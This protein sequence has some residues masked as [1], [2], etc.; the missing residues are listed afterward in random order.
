MTNQVA[1]I[2]KA[3][4]L[5]LAALL[6]A[7]EERSSASA[8]DRLPILKINSKRKDEQG[9]KLEQGLFMLQGGTDEPVYASKVQI[10][11]LSQLF[12]WIHF[13][14]EEKKVE[15]KTLMIPNFGMEAR[16]M[17]GGIRCGKPT[18][19]VL[20]EMPKAEQKKFEDIKC[21]RQLRV[22]VS[23]TGKDADGDEHTIENMPAI[24]FLKGAN[25]NPFNDE[26]IKA[27][28]KGANL[29]DYNIEVTAE[30][31]E[32]GSVV[33]YVMHFKPELKTKLGLDQPTYD[34]MLHMAK[35]IQKDN[36]YVDNQYKKA[37]S[38][39]QVTDDAIDA[40]D[41]LDALEADLED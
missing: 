22:L 41:A 27:L 13:N 10:R 20:Y 33:Y 24:M 4:E 26:V 32:N 17:K 2:D 30:E 9:R 6:G 1:V 28:P 35:M 15:N 34:T 31:L 11:V 36:E 7:S 37:L 19:K 39:N 5:K 12:Q 18:S 25:F 3:E 38:D 29:Y 8:G 16:D 23:Y 40:L 14:A 21:Y